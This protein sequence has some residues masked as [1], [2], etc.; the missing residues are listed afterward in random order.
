MRILVYSGRDLAH[1]A[2]GG[3]EVYTHE[4]SSRWALAGHDVTLFAAAAPDVDLA[5]EDEVAGVRVVRQGNAMTVYRAAAGFYERQSGGWDLVIDEV[6]TRPFGCARWV[7]D[8]PVVALVHQ[9]AREVSFSKMMWPP[10]AVRRHWLEPRWLR[11]LRHVPILTVSP[12]TRQSLLDYGVKQVVVVPQGMTEPPVL[13]SL[14]KETDPTLVFVGRLTPNKRPH[15]VVAAFEIVRG[16]FP[17]AQ[18]WFVGDGPLL[19]ALRRIRVDGV[20]AW[21]RVDDVTKFRLMAAAHLMVATSVRDGW[22]RVVDEAAAVGTASVG[23]DVPGLRDSIPAAGGTLTAENPQSLAAAIIRQLPA[24]LA[25]PPARP[26]GP[27][28]GRSWDEVAA[29]VLDSALA[30]SRLRYSTRN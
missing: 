30:A 16:E 11:G 26:V 5:P 18:L 22:G 12:S 8:A 2:A 28:P 24:A 7:R 29:V 4:V 10:V 9:V 25:A 17:D 15:D 6:N 23:Y 19:G 20:T 21:G 27:L 14:Q 3:A 13:P 1:P